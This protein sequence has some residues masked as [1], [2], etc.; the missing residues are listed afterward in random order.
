M[1]QQR[2]HQSRRRRRGRFSGLYRLLSVLAAAAAIIA[3]C[4][5]FF[6]VNEV[7]VAGNSHYTA[8]EIVAASGIEPGDNLIA[9]SQGRVAGSIRTQLPYVESVT[10]RRQL[11][12]GVLLTVTERVAAASIQ[13]GGGRWLISAQ[14]KILEE[15]GEQRVVAITGLTALTPYAGGAVRTEE[16]DQAT[17]DHAL[18]LLSALEEAEMLTQ[19]T[20]LDCSGAASLTLSW[21]IYQVKFPRGGDYTHMLRLLRAAMDSEEMPKGEPG[22]FDFTVKEGELYFQRSR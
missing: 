3:A 9:L 22:T 15:A 20:R 8:E 5:V 11:P 4:V 2:R 16:E 7:T 13:G 18:S 6:R 14:G 21:D 10:V 1:A 17:L 12:D 19:C